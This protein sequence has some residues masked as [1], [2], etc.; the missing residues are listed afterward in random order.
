MVSGKLPGAIAKTNVTFTLTDKT[1]AIIDLL[2]HDPVAGRARY[3]L[4]SKLAEELFSR[5]FEAVQKGQDE[6]NIRDLRCEVKP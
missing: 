1:V 2:V 3:G 4:K 5:F 6:I